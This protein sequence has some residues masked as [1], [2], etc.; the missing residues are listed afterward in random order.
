MNN[1]S[2]AGSLSW[3]LEDLLGGTKG[4]HSDFF[5]TSLQLFYKYS[6][7]SCHY[8]HNCVCPSK[9]QRNI[10][11]HYVLFCTAFLSSTHKMQFLIIDH[12]T[13][14]QLQSFSS[15]C[16]CK[17]ATITVLLNL[18]LLYYEAAAPLK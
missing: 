13:F 10:M 17:S 16:F 7:G 2:V 12:Q 5:T 15:V 18:C 4:F 11:E 14:S 8:G 6:L 9:R 1:S 3:S